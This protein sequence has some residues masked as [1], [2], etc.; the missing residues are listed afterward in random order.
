[1]LGAASATAAT[2]PS[3]T[4][5][6]AGSGVEHQLDNLQNIQDSGL[7]DSAEHV[8]VTA[9]LAWSTAWTGLRTG[10]R[11]PLAQQP[12]TDGSIVQGSDVKDACGLDLSLAP[13]GWVAQATCSA[14][15][16]VS[17]SPTLSIVKRS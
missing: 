13:P 12:L 8:D 10:G 9:N 5:T 15:L 7:C 17:A 2:T 4:V 11:A 3:Y 6:F 14:S 1:M 16:A